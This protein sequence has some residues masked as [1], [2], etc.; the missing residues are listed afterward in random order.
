M[1]EHMRSW[2]SDIMKKY[3]E[4]KKYYGTKILNNYYLRCIQKMSKLL[5]QIIHKK[6]CE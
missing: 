2:N 6:G 5:I 4:E 1:N 3:F